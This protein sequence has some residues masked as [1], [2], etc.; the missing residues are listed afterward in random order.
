MTQNGYIAYYGTHTC[1][2]RADTSI[3]ARDKAIAIFQRDNSRRHIKPF[4]VSIML[5]F[6]SDEIYIHTAG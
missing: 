3:T 5:A 4:E 6:K 1:E 2:V